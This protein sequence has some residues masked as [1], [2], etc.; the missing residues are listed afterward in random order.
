MNLKNFPVDGMKKNGV[1]ALGIAA[2]RGNVQM[3]E[4]LSE[5]ADL[6]FTTH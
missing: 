4:L 5:K 3:M 2:Y 1:T 6:A